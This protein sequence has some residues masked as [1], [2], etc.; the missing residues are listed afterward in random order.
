MQG[1]PVEHGDRVSAF[2]SSEWVEACVNGSGTTCSFDYAGPLTE[3]VLLGNVAFRVGR[4]IAW[5]S[6]A[7]KATNAKKKLS[8]T[9]PSASMV[10]KWVKQAKGLK[11][12]IKY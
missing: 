11:P 4:W 2:L 8:R 5:D 10:E 1:F 9:S 6:A 7:M 3:A 12:A